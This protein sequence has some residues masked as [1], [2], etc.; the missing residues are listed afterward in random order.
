MKHSASDGSTGSDHREPSSA[1]VRKREVRAVQAH[2]RLPVSRQNAY[3][4]GGCAAAGP[5]R[6][7][8]G[9]ASTGRPQAELGFRPGR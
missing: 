8:A 7:I 5:G 4:L 9:G 2:D 1:A 6:A 3:A